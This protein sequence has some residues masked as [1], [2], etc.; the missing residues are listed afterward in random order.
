M[1][2]RSPVFDVQALRQFVI[3]LWPKEMGATHGVAHWDRVAR[4]G[5]RLYVEGADREVIAAFAYLHDSQRHS[6]GPDLEHGPRAARFV[7]TLRHTYLEALSDEQ[8]ALLKQACELHTV[9]HRTGN[10]TVDIC[11]DADRLDLTRVGIT[12]NP[13][14]MATALGARLASSSS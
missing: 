4:N 8:I 9:E 1:E 11:F 7:D 6:N 10:L 13:H 2:T 5:E 12:P 14:R 3:E